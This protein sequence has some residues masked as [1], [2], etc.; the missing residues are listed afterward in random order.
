M[1]ARTTRRGVARCEA[2][3]LEAGAVTAASDP[4]ATQHAG[5]RGG[6]RSAARRASLPAAVAVASALALGGNDVAGRLQ[7][8]RPAAARI[9]VDPGGGA[10]IDDASPNA[11]GFPAARL[12]SDE[13]RAF[14]VGNSFFKQN[15]VEAP[16]ST[17]ARDGLGP[18]FNARSC[19]AC[20]VKDGR[21]RPPDADEPN[22][23]GLLLRVGVRA[24]DGPDRAHPAYGE[25][26]GDSA[27]QGVAPE[28][29]VVLHV[30]T[31]PGAFGDGTPYELAAPRYE[32]ADLSHGPLGDDAVLG[33]RVA[34]H[35]VGLG[36][37]EA[38]PAESILAHADPD[39]R[40][41][42]GI[43]GRAHVLGID[44][45]GTPRLGRLGWKATQP[46]VLAQTAAAF[47]HDMGITSSLFADEALS[48]EQRASLRFV[49]GGAPE[50]DART[51]DRVAF[52]TRALAVPAPRGVER[53]DVQQ[54][55]ALFDAYGCAACHV[56]SFT[57]SAS[58][59]HPAFASQTIAP[60]TDLLLHDLGPELADEKRDGDALPSEWRTAPLWGLGL[61]PV[62]N[63]HSR[64][65]HD[66]RARDLCEAVLWHGG[67]ALRSRER[68]RN[69]PRHEREALLAFLGAL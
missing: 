69:A 25:Q 13:R 56:P 18:F 1:S 20:H 43:S 3:A 19:S 67:E 23:E 12:S 5:L 26:I 42:D 28:A 49:S 2:C 17:A 62:V 27:V 30:E 16:S 51:L 9:A 39:D 24:N 53:A 46:D 68:F 54:G 57:T 45:H 44:E 41:G 21:S 14:A 47:V 60:Y 11:F 40:D 32:L 50:I 66:G 61:V 64:Y 65:L 10:T 52:Y 37:L 48:T 31:R 55:R 4:R 7:A 6:V 29:R 15:W 58:A 34:P 63:G 38:I 8:P 35:L 33:P 22:R 36:L 59:S